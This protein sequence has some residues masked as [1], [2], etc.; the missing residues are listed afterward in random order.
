V[1]EKS[2]KLIRNSTAEFLI[3][4]LQ[5]EK[6]SIEV[7][8]QDGTIWLTQKLM[9]ELFEVSVPTINEHL[10]NNFIS[11][12]LFDVSTIRKFLIVQNLLT[13]KTRVE[14]P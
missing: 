10:K 12:E 6:N 13:G 5:N 11:N 1:K 4:T 9:A 8:Y 3:F 7:R 2:I 14:V